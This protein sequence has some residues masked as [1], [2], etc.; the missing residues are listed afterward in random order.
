MKYSFEERIK[1]WET[2]FKLPKPKAKKPV[3]VDTINF[4][5]SGKLK[6]CG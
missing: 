3:M 4:T 2:E 1:W 6:Y 5:D